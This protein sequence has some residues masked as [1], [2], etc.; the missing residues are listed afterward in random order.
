MIEHEIEIK[1]KLGLHARAA[2]KLVH[3]AARFKC[4]IKIR[5]GDE[6]VDGKSI[7]GILLLAAGRGTMITIK[8]NGE[9]EG[10]A[11]HAIEALIN[12]KF[13]EVE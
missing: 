1:N 8:A 9:D 13:D 2:A 12:A 6:E 4:D 11:V 3:V 7:L 10:D 5:K